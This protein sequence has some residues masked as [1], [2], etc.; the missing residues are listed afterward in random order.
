MIHALI[1]AFALAQVLVYPAPSGQCNG[2]PGTADPHT[3][4]TANVGVT[5]PVPVG[6]IT[7]TCSV[8]I[9]W[10]LGSGSPSANADLLKA[11]THWSWY[12]PTATNAQVMPAATGTCYLSAI[13]P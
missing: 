10:F 4:V 6:C 9:N 12:Q 1:A 2:A 7:L 8:D 13:V 5:I 3:A 11:G